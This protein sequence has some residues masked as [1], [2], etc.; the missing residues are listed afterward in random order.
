MSYKH[1][2]ILVAEEQ[3]IEHNRICKSLNELGYRTLTPVRSFRE[4]L[5]VT[6]YSFEPFEHFDLLVINGELIAAAGIDS[7]RFFQS[8]SQIRHG[9]IY[10]ARRG[11]AQAETIYANQRRQLT[12]IRTPDR[13]TLAALL[14]HLDI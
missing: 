5:G 7:V 8:N 10:D 2:R 6:H 9:V 4:L 14:E 12:L 13:Q 3:L 1:W 11:Q